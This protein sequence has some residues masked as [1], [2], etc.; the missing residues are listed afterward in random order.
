MSIIG[1]ALMGAVD[2]GRGYLQSDIKAEAKAREADEIASRQEATD[3]RRDDLA[4][5]R[6]ITTARLKEEFARNNEQ[7]KYERLGK[8]GESIEKEAGNIELK[9]SSGLINSIRNQVPNEGE[10]ANKELSAD[11]I[12]TIRTKLSPADAEKFY[13]LKPQTEL[14]KTDDQIAA[15]RAVGAYESRPALIEQRKQLADTDKQDRLE[16]KNMTVDALKREELARKSAKDENDYDIKTRREDTRAEQVA[17]AAKAEK[18]MTF[19]DGQRKEIA[20]ES[21][22][23]NK[24]MAADLKASEY[25][26]PEVRAKIKE[27]YKARFDELKV[28]R[29]QLN[30][31]FQEIRGNFGLSTSKSDGGKAPY[32]DGTRL[33]GKD[34]KSYVVKNGVP[35]IQ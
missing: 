2:V 10:F 16:R 34:G 35:V 25:E 31:D 6:A 30:K 33:S 12:A 32:P 15:A 14:S 22:E 18:V 27:G 29:E 24:Q 17:K 3:I 5:K 20:S 28:K 21:A 1:D 26:N 4:E 7:A 23:I 8:E 13:G 9:R 11:D 19:I